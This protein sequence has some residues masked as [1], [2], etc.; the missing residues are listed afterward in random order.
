MYKIFINE[1]PL[2]ISEH[3]IKG[4][5]NLPYESQNT[6]AIAF[7]MLLHTHKKAINIFY[8]DKEIIW[9]EFQKFAIPVYAAGGVVKNNNH[10]Y[11]FIKRNG[12]WDLPKGHVEKGETYEETAL[13][14]V[15]EECSIH[16][17]TLEN[18]LCTTYH[19][20]FD[21][22]Y[23]LKIVHWFT[24]YSESQELKPQ[25]EENIEVVV[26]VSKEQIT[27]LMNNTYENIK[28]LVY[29]FILKKS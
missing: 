5:V 29:E 20:Y 21:K 18:P 1:K 9:T 4:D 17:L 22:K 16:A 8:F 25:K 10:K 7:D 13:R 24:M 14:E 27:D 11:L 3:E 15:E 19:V 6:F 23:Y 26:W 28:D 12:K 2:T